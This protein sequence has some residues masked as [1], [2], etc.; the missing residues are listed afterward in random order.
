MWS[1]SFTLKTDLGG[2]KKGLK[3]CH[4]SLSLTNSFGILSHRKVAQKPLSAQLSEWKPLPRTWVR[5][6]SRAVNGSLAA[7][8]V[9]LG[10]RCP[11][12][13]VLPVGKPSGSEGSEWIPSL[14][15]TIAQPAAGTAHPPAERA[16]GPEPRPALD[17]PSARRSTRRP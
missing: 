16:A 10:S 11:F 3:N 9:S 2:K 6:S 14:H 8:S 17:L 1:T 15:R 13:K 7:K 12:S 4:P 5:D